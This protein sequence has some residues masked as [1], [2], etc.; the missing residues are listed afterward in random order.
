MIIVAARVLSAHSV[1]LT[2]FD[3]AGSLLSMVMLISLVYAING[4]AQ[5]IYWFI[6]SFVSLCAFIF[7]ERKVSAPMLPLLI[8]KNR[9]RSSAYIIRALF[10]GSMMGYFFF[11]AEFLQDTLH[12]SPLMTGFAF[13][14]L[15]LATFI[16]ALRVP[17]IIDRHS[18]KFALLCGVA[19]LM[20]GFAATVVL[21][22]TQNYWAVIGGPSIL[23]GVGQ[24]FAMSPLTNLGIRD[25][26]EKDS[27]AASGMVNAAHEVGGSIGLSVMVALTGGLTSFNVEFKYA[28]LV[29]FVLNVIGLL[30]AFLIK[31]KSAVSKKKF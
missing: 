21:L 1:H 17:N 13:L 4:A 24:G 7:V 6:L 27:G 8:F 23:L 22:P 30:I 26:D 9:T 11:A 14:P 20:L 31:S 10:V 25:I 12:F 15:T 29:A 5:P 3:F 19:L 16:A 2:H 18:N 28:M